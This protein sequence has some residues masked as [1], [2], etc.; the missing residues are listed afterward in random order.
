MCPF[1]PAKLTFTRTCRAKEERKQGEVSVDSW[2]SNRK[3]KLQMME[4]L[5]FYPEDCALGKKQE[6]ERTEKREEKK[7]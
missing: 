4:K 7:R 5:L 3:R 6:N 1:D 2:T